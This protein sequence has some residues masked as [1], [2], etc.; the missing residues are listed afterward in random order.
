MCVCVCW[1][2][3]IYVPDGTDPIVRWIVFVCL[4]L[5]RTSL[6]NVEFE[7]AEGMHD[8]LTVNGDSC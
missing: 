7:L 2:K 5:V 3:P 8:P 6:I 4:S 1:I